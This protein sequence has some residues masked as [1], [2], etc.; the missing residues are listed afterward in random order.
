M[1]NWNNIGKIK[2]LVIFILCILSIIIKDFEKKSETNYDFY[3]GII[4]VIFLFNILF[5]PLITKFWSLFGNAFDK[6]NWNENPITF[7]SSKS[8]NFFQFIAFWFMS[9]GLINVLLFGIINQQFDGEN[10]LLF[11]GGLSLFIGM[12]IS[13]KWL[14]K[15]A[16]EKS[17]TLPLTKSQK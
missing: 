11:F 2:S 9:A 14:N 7:K 16:K 3:I 8:F 17:K 5:F 10:A 13:V 1:K 6:P 12:K 15:G 4:I